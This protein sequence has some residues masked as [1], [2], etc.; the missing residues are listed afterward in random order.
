MSQRESKNVQ[1]LL[2]TRGYN[3]YNINLHKNKGGYMKKICSLQARKQENCIFYVIFTS[4]LC[5]KAIG[6]YKLD[7][8]KENGFDYI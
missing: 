5:I 7:V 8:K 2:S 4:N 3:N 1:Y 6:M